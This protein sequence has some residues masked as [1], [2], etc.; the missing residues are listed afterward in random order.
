[1]LARGE[2]GG[3][4]GAQSAARGDWG[5]S[6]PSDRLGTAHSAASTK[7]VPGWSV[8]DRT[9]TAVVWF[10]NRQNKSRTMHITIPRSACELR[11][12]AC[13]LYF[14]YGCGEHRMLANCSSP[15]MRRSTECLRI[16]VR[17]G[18]SGAPHACESSFASAAAE[19]IVLAIVVANIVVI[20]TAVSTHLTN[21]APLH[22][23]THTTTHHNT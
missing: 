7:C 16:V 8:F 5:G 3:S 19:H 14:G 13:E 6:V 15:R 2:W 17:H 12:S 1:V 23:L 22:T 4:G 18:C 10:G 11:V 9:S 20:V 21:T